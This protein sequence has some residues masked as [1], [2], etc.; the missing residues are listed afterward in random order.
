MKN[1]LNEDIFNSSSSSSSSPSSSSSS[2]TN[3]D[4]A[5]IN[6]KKKD[7]NDPTLQKSISSMKGAQVNVIDETSEGP[8]KLDYLSDLHDKSTGDISQPF[9]INGKNYQMCRA[10]NPKKEKVLGVYSIDESSD[11]NHVIYEVDYFE[12][13]IISGTPAVKPSTDAPTPVTQDAGPMETKESEQPSFA[14]F[15]HF[16]VN[17]KSGKSRKIKNLSDLAKAQM[18]E[19]EEY[20]GV[21]DF[22]KWIDEMLFG[23]KKKMMQEEAP[24]DP[25]IIASSQKLMDMISQRISPQVIQNIQKNTIAQ[26]EVI[27]AFAKMIGVPANELNKIINGIRSVTTKGPSTTQTD[28]SSTTTA[29]AVAES[30]I[31]KKKDLK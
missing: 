30:K 25:T 16:I 1:Q 4:A 23:A 2:S 31:V 24:T 10:M 9:T 8:V 15:K 19:D 14:G 20:M 17:R 6:V 11:D 18:T 3:K 22:K 29:T 12:N 13:N 26:R 21:N 5:T 27:I 28:A 7:M